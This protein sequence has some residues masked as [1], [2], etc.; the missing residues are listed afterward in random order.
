LGIPKF[1]T[2][3]ECDEHVLHHFAIWQGQ[4][5]PAVLRGSKKSRMRTYHY[6]QF[7]H[8]FA[9]TYNGEKYSRILFGQ[10]SY[11]PLGC[12]TM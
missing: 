7:P 2:K 6:A 8:P 12:G 3:R 5:H 11:S 4:T 1:L 9:I 10:T